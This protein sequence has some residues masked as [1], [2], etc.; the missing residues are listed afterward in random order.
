MSTLYQNK[1]RNESIRLQHWD[2]AN[3]GAYFI[4]ICTKN[5]AHFFGEIIDGEMHLNEIGEIANQEWIKTPDIRPDM[6]LKLGEFVVMPNHFHAVLII[7]ENQ[8]NQQ[9][10]FTQFHVIGGDA[11]HCVPTN[12]MKYVVPAKQIRPPIQKP[13]IRHPWIQI[14]CNN[15][16]KKNDGC[17]FEYPKYNWL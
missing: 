8:Y 3:A 4:T 13:G 2:Y 6:N 9:N 15:P 7:G 11:M 5:R 10:D 1:Y 12:H 17:K 16:G 14:F